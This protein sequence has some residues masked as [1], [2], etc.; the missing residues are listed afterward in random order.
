MRILHATD[1]H[2]GRTGNPAEEILRFREI[3]ANATERFRVDAWIHTGDILDR[4]APISVYKEY[5]ASEPPFLHVPGNHDDTDAMGGIFH[6][7]SDEFPYAKEW[8]GVRF[9]GLD[10]SSGMLGFRQS[11]RL[12]D[13]LSR[14]RPSIILIHHQFQPFADSW[15]NPY[16]LKDAEDLESILRRHQDSVLAVF[17][18]H[19]HAARFSSVGTI[20]VLG[21]P[22]AAYQFD[23]QAPEKTVSSEQ[24]EAIVVDIG[25]NSITLVDTLR[26]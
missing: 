23:P 11:R 4:T 15:L 21:G 13:L 2:F 24:G 20:P 17:H 3:V 8:N 7:A 9:I 5:I 16:L 6:E 25:E 19:F 10:S 12:G 18:G 26:F 1:T 22:S 14:K